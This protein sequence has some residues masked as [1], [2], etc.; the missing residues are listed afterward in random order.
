ML[1]IEKLARDS[2]FWK[3]IRKTQWS[4]R[5]SLFSIDEIDRLFSCLRKPC[6]HGQIS[7]SLQC[8]ASLSGIYVSPNLCRAQ[9]ESDCVVWLSVD[10]ERDFLFFLPREIDE[11]GLLKGFTF[12]LFSSLKKKQQIIAELSFRFI[13]VHA[14]HLRDRFSAYL[15]SLRGHDRSCRRHGDPNLWIHWSDNLPCQ[16]EVSG[17][18]RFLGCGLLNDLP[19]RGATSN[20]IAPSG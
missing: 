12:R 17:V 4:R 10:Y 3:L 2:K 19:L 13:N 20:L 16:D 1:F 18:G 11:K 7:R 9:P 8:Q 6:Q 14:S 5:K 15:I